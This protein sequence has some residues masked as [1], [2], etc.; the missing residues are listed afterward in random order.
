M[1]ER[2]LTLRELNR[3]LLARQLLL[4]SAPPA[5]ACDRAPFSALQPWSAAPY[6][7]L[8]TRLEELGRIRNLE[9]ALRSEDSSRRRSCARRSISCRA[10][11]TRSSPQGSWKLA[12]PRS[13][14]RYPIDLDVI[15]NRLRLATKEPPATS[16]GRRALMITLA[17]RSSRAGRSGRC[18]R[19]RSCMRRLVHLPPSRIY[20]FYHGAHFIPYKESIGAAPDVPSQPM[21]HLLRRFLAASTRP[22]ST[23]SASS[24]GMP[25]RRSTQCSSR[26]RERSTTRPA[27]C[28]TTSHAR[29]S[30][31]QDTQ[32]STPL[33]PQV[34]TSLL[35]TRPWRRANPP[36]T[37]TAKQ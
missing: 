9:R 5:V 33:L 2:V 36:P 18:R 26:R 29:H 27:G 19:S 7:A 12:A 14:A 1:S 24:I 16:N 23:T 11:T 28:C 17:G 4:Q 37:A 6:I 35:A 15:A 31:P 34:R 22:R 10:P 30:L 25:R 8:W 21:R 3:A 20:S 13:S 32:H